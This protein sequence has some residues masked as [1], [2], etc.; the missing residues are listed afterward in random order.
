MAAKGGRTGLLDKWKIDDKPV[1]IDKWD[2]SAVKNS[3]DDSAKKV[4]PDHGIMECSGLERP[5]RSSSSNPCHRQG[6]LPLEQ[7]LQ[8]P[9][10]NLALSTARDGAATASLGTL[11]QRLSTLP[12]NSFCLISN[13][14]FPCFS[15]TPSPLVL[16]LQ[17]LMKSPSPASL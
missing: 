3:L 5:I 4:T 12:G 9:V 6:P 1:K 13:L 17:S 15:L 16:S 7:L 8:A 14:N 11:C 10:S 2:G